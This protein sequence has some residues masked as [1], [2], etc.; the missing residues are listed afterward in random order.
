MEMGGGSGLGEGTL[1]MPWRRWRGMLTA[2]KASGRGGGQERGQV[3]VSE[4]QQVGE[5]GPCHPSSQLLPPPV[6][7]RHARERR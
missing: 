6:K 5:G 7:N 4:G 3:M 2:V 1:A